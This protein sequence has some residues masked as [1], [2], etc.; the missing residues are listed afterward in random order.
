MNR[1]T[2]TTIFLT[3]VLNLFGQENTEYPSKEEKK[4]Y[5]NYRYK[6]FKPVGKSKILNYKSNNFNIRDVPT[7]KPFNESLLLTPYQD[8][9]LPILFDPPIKDSIVIPNSE[10]LGAID[11]FSILKHEKQGEIESFIY[12][13]FEYE[14]RFFGE[15]GIWIGYSTD[16]GKNWDYYYTGIVQK[17]PVFIKWYSAIPL[18][19]VINDKIT[20]QIEGAL[21]RQLE[22]FT[23]PGPL[24]KYKIIKDGICIVFDLSTLSKDSDNDG[25]TDIVENKLHTDSQNKDTD[26]DSIPDNIDLNPR[27]NLPKTEKTAIYEAIIN[28]QIKWDK[29]VGYA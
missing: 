13:S 7:Y 14:D 26:N 29:G 1:I 8:S 17:Q 20:I 11:R 5:R 19:N 25:L 27:F 24:P 18:I 2:L 15:P 6:S 22:P 21:L 4:Y 28:E 12:W 23:H 10:Y 9:I 3:I 16:G